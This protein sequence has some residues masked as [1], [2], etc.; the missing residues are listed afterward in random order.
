MISVR[1]FPTI[2]LTQSRSELA[3]FFKGKSMDTKF[4]CLIAFL[5]FSS[6]SLV[7]HSQDRFQDD[8][9][10]KDQQ[11]LSRLGYLD[12]Q[13]RLLHGKI[14]LGQPMIA[15]STGTITLGGEWIAPIE[16]IFQ[17]FA[18]VDE[19]NI[20]SQEIIEGFREM[21]SKGSLCLYIAASFMGIDTS[22][23]RLDEATRNSIKKN[24]YALAARTTKIHSLKP[25]QEI[26][27]RNALKA[28]QVLLDW[29]KQLKEDEKS[30]PDISRRFIDRFGTHFVDQLHEG[31]V[32]R[33][34]ASHSE[35]DESKIAA[36]TAKIQGS[37]VVDVD[38]KLKVMKE[39]NLRNLDAVIKVSSK[40]L[41]RLGKDDDSPVRD[42]ATFDPDQVYSAPGSIIGISV[43]PYYEELKRADLNNLAKALEDFPRGVIEPLA[44]KLEL[45]T[46]GVSALWWKGDRDYFNGAEF[47]GKRNMTQNW[48]TSSLT[49]NGDSIN[50]AFDVFVEEPLGDKTSAKGSRNLKLFTAP[51]GYEIVGIRMK[52]G[53][54]EIEKVIDRGQKISYESPKSDSVKV[55]GKQEYGI[56][57]FDRRPEY[58]GQGKLQ[59]FNGKVQDEVWYIENDLGQC[60]LPISSARIW[61]TLRFGTAGLRERL[62][63]TFLP[64]EVLM[65]KKD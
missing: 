38:G 54:R 33:L 57:T 14:R 45:G 17:N 23:E 35:F 27:I 48:F 9:Y 53:D 26:D 16:D 31:F 49:N 15:K 6:F 43:K 46:Y 59:F 28:N 24:V 1:F 61:S 55:G 10:L 19:T 22:F 47:N 50:L 52:V 37:F 3:V 20:E 51:N 41:L 25:N 5:S 29:E 34:Q 42:L 56:V 32:F 2:I 44:V 58:A 36:T 60:E 64:F 13:S 30:A 65:Q 18:D 63:I 40:G 39:D 4:L 7:V 12:V 21:N 8:P 62:E 11:D